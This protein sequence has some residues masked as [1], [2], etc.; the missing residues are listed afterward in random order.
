[1]YFSDPCP[2]QFTFLSETGQCYLVSQRQAFSWSEAEQECKARGAS[3]IALQTE[4]KYE[5]I[6]NWYAVSKYA[7]TMPIEYHAV[8][9]WCKINGTYG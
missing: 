6:K 9:D 1:M 2:A 7:P 3:L 5:T 4:E 8:F